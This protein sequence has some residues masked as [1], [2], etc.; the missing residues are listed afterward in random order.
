MQFRLARET[1]R[2]LIEATQRLSPEQRLEAF[3]EHG[4]LV[5]ELYE[6]GGQMKRPTTPTSHR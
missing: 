2:A 6:A 4:R 1:E 3:L 5:M